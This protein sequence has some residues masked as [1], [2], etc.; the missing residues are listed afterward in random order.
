MQGQRVAAT[1]ASGQPQEESAGRGCG[2]TVDTPKSSALG[3]RTGWRL[4]TSGQERLPQTSM[5]PS[6]LTAEQPLWDGARDW[7]PSVPGT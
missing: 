1:P 3:P 4:S 6:T 7:P 2:H 5:L